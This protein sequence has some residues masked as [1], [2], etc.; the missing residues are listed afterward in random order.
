MADPESYK[1][2]DEAKAMT[3]EYQQSKPRLEKAFA[4]WATCTQAIDAIR[5]RNAA[6]PA[7]EKPRA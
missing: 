7:A 5:A 6:P 2:A 3:L 4:E 1:H